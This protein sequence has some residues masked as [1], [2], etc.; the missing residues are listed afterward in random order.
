VLS[1]EFRLLEPRVPRFLF[2]IFK[3]GLSLA[4]VTEDLPGTSMAI[5]TAQGMARELLADT[6]GEWISARLEV[7]DEH[8]DVIGVIHMRDYWLQ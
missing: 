4:A 2:S 5:S 1:P 8:G 7:A 6:E 3:E